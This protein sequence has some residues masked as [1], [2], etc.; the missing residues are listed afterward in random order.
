MAI[1]TEVLD[2]GAATMLSSVLPGR[3]GTRR[4]GLGR[5]LESAP[6]AARVG[7]IAPRI[8][9]TSLLPCLAAFKRSRGGL[10]ERAGLVMGQPGRWPRS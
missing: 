3:A 4:T 9:G 8:G 5:P 10:S 7:L 1:G 2:L 6:L